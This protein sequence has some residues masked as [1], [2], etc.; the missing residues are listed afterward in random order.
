MHDLDFHIS[1]ECMEG[2]Y[3]LHCGQQCVG[4]CIDGIPCNHVT[5]V[6]DRGCAPGWAAH[7]CYKATLSDISILHIKC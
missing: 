4:H 6:C 1:L 7:K 5:G 2:W 3:G